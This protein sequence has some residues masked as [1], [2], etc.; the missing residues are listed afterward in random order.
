M[1]D[2]H[3]RANAVAA[4]DETVRDSEVRQVNFQSEVEHF[5]LGDVFGTGVDKYSAPL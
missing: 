5:I 2:E 3:L 4:K 1:F